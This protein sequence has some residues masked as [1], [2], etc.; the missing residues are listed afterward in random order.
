MYPLGVKAMQR[1]KIMKSKEKVAFVADKT[2]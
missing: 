2:F 1:E